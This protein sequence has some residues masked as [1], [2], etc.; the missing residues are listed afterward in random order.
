MGLCGHLAA[1]RADANAGPAAEPTRALLVARTAT[2]R[3]RDR[4][5]DLPTQEPRPER[6]ETGRSGLLL[7]REVIVHLPRSSL[8]VSR[9]FGRDDGLKSVAVRFSSA[10][11]RVDSGN[12]A[13]TPQ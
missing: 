8:P 3:D 5:P 11:A 4:P 7:A 12:R 10:S 13:E 1:D 9:N 2:L 6:A